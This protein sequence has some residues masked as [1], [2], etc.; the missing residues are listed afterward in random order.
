MSELTDLEKLKQDVE[1]I[2][3]YLEKDVSKLSEIYRD[4]RGLNW[5][6]CREFLRLYNSIKYATFDEL[7]SNTERDYSEYDYF[8]SFRI[9]YNTNEMK[10][11]ELW[12]K[13]TFH[14]KKEEK[15]VKIES[16]ENNLGIFSIIAYI[17]LHHWR[18][19]LYKL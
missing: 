11:I 6:T 15:L 14:L 3:S 19:F 10:K 5:D 1:N 13:K 18:Y 17:Y 2:K 16:Q 12:V 7:I 4:M 9:D 8:N